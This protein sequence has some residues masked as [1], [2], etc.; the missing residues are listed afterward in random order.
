[1]LGSRA[2]RFTLSLVFV[3]ALSACAS[4]PHPEQPAEAEWGPCL[5]AGTHEGMISYAR[6]IR[7]VAL[8]AEA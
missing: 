1:M 6:C 3:L 4:P 7:H 2:M 5:G 8:P